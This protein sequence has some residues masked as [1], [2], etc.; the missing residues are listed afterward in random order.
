M[1]H[2]LPVDIIPTYSAPIE[3][4]LPSSSAIPLQSYQK[5]KLIKQLIKMKAPSLEKLKEHQIIKLKLNKNNSNDFIMKIKIFTVIA[6][7]MAN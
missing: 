2:N 3:Y 4:D 7:T 6:V 5:G 1:N